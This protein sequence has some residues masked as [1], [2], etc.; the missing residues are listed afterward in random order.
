MLGLR[1]SRDLTCC[2]FFGGA[3]RLYIETV[4]SIR[5]AAH[6][7]DTDPCGAKAVLFGM[8]LDQLFTC[9][10]IYLQMISSRRFLP[11]SQSERCGE[12][13]IVIEA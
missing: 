12:R 2:H 1:V 9:S 3:A 6:P 11:L 8:D 4:Q 10:V 5:I 13:S 7:E